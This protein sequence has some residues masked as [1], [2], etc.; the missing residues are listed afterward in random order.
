MRNWLQDK[1][2]KHY[3]PREYAA[4]TGGENFCSSGATDFEYLDYVPPEYKPGM[5]VVVS[6][7]GSKAEIVEI[8][9]VS[10]G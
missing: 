7:Q 1:W 10:N 2:R 8:I 5:K 3:S 6:V 9:S 4:A